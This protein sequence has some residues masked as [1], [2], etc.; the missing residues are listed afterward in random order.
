M[1]ERV[2]DSIVN[3]GNKWEKGVCL[4]VGMFDGVHCGHR[5]VLDLAIEEAQSC[6][7]TSVALSFPQHPASYLRP[8]K[9]PPLLMPSLDKAQN[10]LDAGMDAVILQPFDQLLSSLEAE[11][12]LPYLREQI[13]VLQSVSV[14]ENFRFGKNRMGDSAVL[15]EMGKVYG[16]KVRVAQSLVL[17]ESPVSSSRIRH[18]LSDGKITEVNQMLGR[19]YTVK[20]KVICGKALGRT[21]GFPTLNLEWNPQARPALGV[22]AGRVKETNTGEEMPAVANYGLRPTLESQVSVPLLEIHCLEQPDVSIWREGAPLEMQ[23]NTF[24]RPEMKF[25]TVEELSAQITKDCTTA[26]NLFAE[27]L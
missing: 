12:F 11:Q 24:L 21:L 19:T 16:V 2:F 1:M 13:P 10:L 17:N 9:E 15:K 25:A 22:Y 27:L 23:L 26:R 3:F 14:G 5:K 6:S 18:A 20:G 4:A 8:G 7:G